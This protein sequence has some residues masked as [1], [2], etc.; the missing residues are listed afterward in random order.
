MWNTAET[1]LKLRSDSEAAF[2][3]IQGV[4][5]QCLAGQPITGANLL[6]VERALA[7][8][9]G[10]NCLGGGCTHRVQRIAENVTSSY[11][12]FSSEV[13]VGYEDSRRV[14]HEH[15]VAMRRLLVVLILL[16]LSWVTTGYACSMD[17]ATAQPVF[18]CDAAS[19]RSCPEPESG[20]ADAAMT[21]ASTDGCCSIVVTSITVAQE[22][23]NTSAVIGESHLPSYKL[24][25]QMSAGRNISNDSIRF[26]CGLMR[27]SG[28]TDR[29]RT[30]GISTSPCQGRAAC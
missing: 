13:I 20:C 3:E 2:R 23:T 19:L 16:S 25:M 4:R 6:L 9:I 15:R 30:L 27:R 17:S 10:A 8:L 28:W 7:Q 22:Q 24:G 1:I 11:L 18:C 21:G 12:T 29:R 5:Q 26:A 14:M